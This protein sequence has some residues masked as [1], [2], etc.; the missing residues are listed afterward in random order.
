MKPYFIRGLRKLYYTFLYTHF[1]NRG[2]EIAYDFPC[3]SMSSRASND[4]LMLAIFAV[5][6]RLYSSMTLLVERSVV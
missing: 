1:A 2:S 3:T 5:E 6:A 4:F